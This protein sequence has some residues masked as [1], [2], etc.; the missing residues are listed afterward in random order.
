MNK[1]EKIK[2][3]R[4]VAADRKRIQYRAVVTGKSVKE[5]LFYDKLK[6]WFPKKV[7]ARLSFVVSV[8]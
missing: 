3:D 8:I 1:T 7:A 2:F 6:K 4:Q 5:V